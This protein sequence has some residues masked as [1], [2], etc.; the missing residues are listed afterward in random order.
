MTTAQLIAVC[1]ALKPELSALSVRSLRLFGSHARG[2]ARDDSDLDLLVDFD[3]PATFDTFMD[4]KFLLEDRL[5]RA[6]DL[7]TEKAIRPELR[8][9]I[10]RDAV[11]VA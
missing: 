9:S 8:T 6:V 3:G 5:G 1:T 2:E 10:E 4:V 7:V 11:R